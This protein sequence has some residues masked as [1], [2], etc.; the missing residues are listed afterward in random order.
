MKI[1]LYVAAVGLLLSGMSA[2][3]SA[4]EASGTISLVEMNSGIESARVYLTNVT[5][6]CTG[7]TA[8]W[9]YISGFVDG[10]HTPDI[11]YNAIVAAMLMA[12]SLGSNVDVYST[13]DATTGYCHIF[14]FV[15]H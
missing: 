3:S 5:T 9:A 2:L 6:I 1:K 13:V 14:D 10:S 4:D 12:K 7:S 8:N 15:V 11:N